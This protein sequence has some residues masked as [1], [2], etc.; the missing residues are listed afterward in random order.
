MRSSGQFSRTLHH[1]PARSGTAR[2]RQRERS[3]RDIRRASNSGPL[4]SVSRLRLTTQN[5]KLTE[6]RLLV[7]RRHRRRRRR[8]CCCCCCCCCRCF[9]QAILLLSF[10]SQEKRFCRSRGK[11]ILG[12]KLDISY[13]SERERDL[14]TKPLEFRS[15]SGELLPGRGPPVGGWYYQQ[16]HF[17]V[18]ASLGRRVGVEVFV[19]K[20]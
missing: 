10:E 16:V 6:R 11:H 2:L 13:L 4:H 19:D 7:F 18:G 1:F 9:F 5:T 14:A 15:K 3:V 8:Y 20:L 12:C 17:Y